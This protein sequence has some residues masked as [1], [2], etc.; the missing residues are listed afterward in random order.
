MKISTKRSLTLYRLTLIVLHVFVSFFTQT[1][2]ITEKLNLEGN[3]IEKEAAKFLC[4]MLKENLYIT[5]LV[6]CCS[7]EKN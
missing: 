1:N 2:T 3:G 4:R 6:R 7:V 5:E